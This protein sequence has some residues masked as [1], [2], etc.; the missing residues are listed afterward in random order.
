MNAAAIAPGQV[1]LINNGGATSGEVLFKSLKNGKGVALADLSN[2]DEIDAQLSA[3]TGNSIR[4]GSDN[5]LF[6]SVS[7][8]APV[9]DLVTYLLANGMPVT[10]NVAWGMGGPSL[11]AL[12]ANKVAMGAAVTVGTEPF[13][14]FTVAAGTYDIEMQQNWLWLS[15]VTTGVG[16]GCSI[17][18]MK[19]T[20]AADLTT[21]TAITSVGVFQSL[22]SNANTAQQVVQR[23]VFRDIVMGADPLTQ[24]GIVGQ[25]VNGLANQTASLP[26]FASSVNPSAGN[27]VNQYTN[28]G[29]MVR[30]TPKF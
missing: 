24:Y 13:T 9:S 16:A 23:S 5:G 1:S 30:F 12:A 17:N 18:L 26:T 7:G 19:F 11:D 27:V 2:T 25:F 22:F 6:V 4:L 15:G 20:L 29:L 10:K 3:D 21:V 14:L 28:A 8:P